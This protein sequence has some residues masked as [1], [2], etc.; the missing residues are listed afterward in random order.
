V[1]ELGGGYGE[2]SGFFAALGANVTCVDGRVQNLNVARIRF[3][4]F[5]NI[6]FVQRN[7]EYDFSDL[8][9]FDL[10]IHFGL[11]YHIRNLEQNLASTAVLSDEIVLET[12]VIDSLDPNAK[13]L[14]EQTK[15]HRDRS[16]EGYGSRASPNL[17]KRFFESRGFAVEII[18]DPSL[19]TAQHNYSWNHKN[20]GSHRDGMRRFF[21]IS[22]QKP[23]P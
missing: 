5:D 8:G 9:R 14:V 23:A 4:A 15:A 3:R 2:I 1:I 20:D 7:L 19:N 18:T 12:E 16:L 17:I 11:L 22:K 21:R 10:A 13:V 6:T